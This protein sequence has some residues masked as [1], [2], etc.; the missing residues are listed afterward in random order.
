MPILRQNQTSVSFRNE[1]A[2]I[3]MHSFKK[4]NRNFIK[5]N[6]TTN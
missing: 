4:S 2:V 1:A 3:L 5:L 6:R